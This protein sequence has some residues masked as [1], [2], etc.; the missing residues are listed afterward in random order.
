M[1]S[2]NLGDHM[3]RRWRKEITPRRI[4]SIL[5]RWL[6][7]LAGAGAFVGLIGLGVTPLTSN[8][9]C[10]LTTTQI[11]FGIH[12]TLTWP[13]ARHGHLWPQWW[14]Y[15]LLKGVGIVI[16]QILFWSLTPALPNLVTYFACLLLLKPLNFLVSKFFIFSEEPWRFE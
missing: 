12:R 13:N 1:L 8:L 3:M 11:R 2:S 5:A 9:L 4:I 10:K 16:N 14:R 6:T 15:Q 7:T